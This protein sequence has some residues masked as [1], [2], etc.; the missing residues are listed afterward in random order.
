MRAAVDMNALGER[1]LIIDCDVIQAD[2]G[3]RTA[4]VTGAFVAHG[5]GLPAASRVRRTQDQ[6]GA[7]STS[8]PPAWVS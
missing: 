7:R 6:S 2:G 1:T 5:N 3:T 4:S 8:R